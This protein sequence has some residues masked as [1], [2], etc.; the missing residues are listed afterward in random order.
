MSRAGAVGEGLAAGFDAERDTMAAIQREN[1]TVWSLAHHRPP[2]AAPRVPAKSC[3][4]V[5]SGMIM[6]KNTS[7]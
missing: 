1:L 2:N 6:T 4:A 5:N 3:I 7:V